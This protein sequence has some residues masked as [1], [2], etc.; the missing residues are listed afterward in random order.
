MHPYSTNSEERTRVPFLLAAVAVVLAWVLMKAR[1][2]MRLPFWLEV[3]GTATLYFLIYE[4][5]RTF[6]WEF[7]ILRFVGIVKVPNLQGRW[8]GYLTSSYDEAAE[9]QPVTVQ[10]TQNWTHIFIK[11]TAP[12][13]NSRSMVGSIYTTEAETLLSYQYENEPNVAAVETMHAHTGTATLEVGADGLTLT[14]S[15]Y[16]GRDRATHGMLVLARAK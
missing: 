4:G 12:T 16:S 5:F 1:G 7:S 6:L 11:L 15:Y 3:P 2:G 10:I 9:K 13:S 14:G 8:T